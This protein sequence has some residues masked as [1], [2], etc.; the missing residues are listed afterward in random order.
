M[1]NYPAVLIGRLGV[2]NNYKGKNIG[3]ELMDF[4]KA[5]FIDSENKTGCRF[6]V[7]DS[8]NTIEAISYYEKNGFK[9]MFSTDDQEKEYYEMTDSTTLGTKLLFFYLILLKS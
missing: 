9:K 1:R 5:W 6:I 2:N 4:I 7:V 8:Y 3:T